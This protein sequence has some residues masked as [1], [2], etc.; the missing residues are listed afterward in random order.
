VTAWPAIVLAIYAGVSA[1]AFAAFGL[2]KWR[3]VCG[4]RRI[5]EATLHLLELA[6]GVPGSLLGQIV[7][8]HKC[9][10]GRYL[11]VFWLIAAAHVAIWTALWAQSASGALGA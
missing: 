6:G 5:P 10:K 3:A 7:F 9:S 11:A 2:D 8:R 1:L 4:R